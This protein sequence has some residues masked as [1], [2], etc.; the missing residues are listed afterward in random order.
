MLIG[1]LGAAAGLPTKT[2]RFYEKSGLLPAPP[3]TSGGYR[4]RTRGPQSPP[5]PLRDFATSCFSAG[6]IGRLVLA[7][8]SICL[9][10]GPCVSCPFGLAW[11]VRPRA[12]LAAVLG[13][14]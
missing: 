14:A 12:F 9:G 5:A 7:C 6:G 13:G 4:D 8:Q 11:D 10:I 2:I 3:R 1:D